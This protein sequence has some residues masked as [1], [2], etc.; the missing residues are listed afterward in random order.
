MALL[1]DIDLKTLDYSYLGQPFVF[2]PANITIDTPT[3]DYSYL[4]QPFVT[5]YGQSQP[6]GSSNF[7]AFMPI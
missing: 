2:V 7:F 1:T 6:I 5:N 3:M 4:G